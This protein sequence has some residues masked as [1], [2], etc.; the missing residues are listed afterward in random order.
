V[1][2]G[3]GRRSGHCVGHGEGGGDQEGRGAR[4]T[5]RTSHNSASSKVVVVESSMHDLV[6]LFLIPCFPPLYPTRLD[7]VP[8]IV[9][10]YD[11]CSLLRASM[12]YDSNGSVSSPKRV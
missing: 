11:C 10:P 7:G 2:K 3:M 4:Y 9:A 5:V 8:V 1:G 12:W 6:Q